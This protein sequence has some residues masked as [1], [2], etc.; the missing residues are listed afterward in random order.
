MLDKKEYN[1][2]STVEAR[3]FGPNEIID[4]LKLEE[5]M[6]TSWY[7]GPLKDICEEPDATLLNL[8]AVNSNV[9]G[10]DIKKVF[11]LLSNE[12][13]IKKYFGKKMG[14]DD[15]TRTLLSK[16]ISTKQIGLALKLWEKQESQEL[17]AIE[18]KLLE[19]II[20]QTSE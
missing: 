5:C 14:Y 2:F 20:E 3:S 13:K 9:N 11:Y 16:P 15:P 1:D 12:E 8:V 17:N 10:L 7:A 4:K 18:A 6:Y 19:S